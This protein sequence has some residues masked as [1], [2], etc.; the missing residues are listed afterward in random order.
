MRDALEKGAEAVVGGELQHDMGLNFFPPALLAGCTIDMRVSNE[1]IFG[2]VVAVRKFAHDEEAL[3]ISNRQVV[4]MIIW[5]SPLFLLYI[6]YSVVHTSSTL[7]RTHRLSYNQQ[8][9]TLSN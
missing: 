3:A 5:F 2:P 9:Q 8:Y 4:S 7:D 6:L 1:E